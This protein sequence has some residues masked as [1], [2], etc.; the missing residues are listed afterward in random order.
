MAHREK[1]RIVGNV[2]CAM[3]DKTMLK[4]QGKTGSVVKRTHGGSVAVLLIDGIRYRIPTKM[5]RTT[6]QG[7]EGVCYE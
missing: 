1:V 6:F 4:L 3:P 5:L 7:N 2:V